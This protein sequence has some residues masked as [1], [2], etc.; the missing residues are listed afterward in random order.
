[1]N[2]AALKKQFT[3][4]ARS[5]PYGTNRPQLCLDMALATA[6]FEQ[7][8][9]YLFMGDGVFQ[10]VRGQNAEG[11]ASKTLGNAMETLDLYGIESVLVEREALSSRSLNE[12]DLLLPV[13]LAEPD[14]IRSLLQRSD[15]VF[16]L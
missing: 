8:V 12:K 16:N 9:N 6:V 10:L 2:E 7:E 14:D 5:A 3:F 11:I 1:M 13:T 4:I 15:C